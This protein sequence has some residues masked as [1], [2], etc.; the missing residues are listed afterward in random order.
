MD[1][2]TIR[3]AIIV[4]GHLMWLSTAALRVVRGSRR[5]QLRAAAPWPIALYPALV[6]LPLVVATVLLRG[7]HELDDATQVVGLAVALGGSVLGAS[8]MWA[9]RGAYGIGLDLFAAHPLKTDGPFAL[10]RHPMY[11]GIIV[12]HVGASLALESLPLVAATALIVVPYTALRIGFE[13][14]VLEEGFGAEY[15]AYARRTPRLLPIPR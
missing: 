8:S 13:E 14:R 3:I 10:V 12:Y 6:W 4:I 5:H 1:D 7:E 15:A 11:L 2:R 9:L